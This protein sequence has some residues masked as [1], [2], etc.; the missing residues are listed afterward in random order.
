MRVIC[1]FTELEPE[2]RDAIDLTG[3]QCEYV[4]V[5]GSDDAY[6]ALLAELWKAGREFCIIEHD[7]VPGRGSLDELEDC[8]GD[9]CSF[10]VAYGTGA[11]AGLGCVKFSTRLLGQ[12]PYALERIEARC[13]DTHPPKHW[14]RLDAW[15]NEYLR[16]HEQRPCIH[17]PA[18]THL[19]DEEGP[20]QPSH[21][22]G[23]FG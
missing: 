10:A 8:P 11:H 13:D 17:I 14:C 16:N 18:L 21:G 5:S 19:R 6:W 20:V 2:T 4:D 23:R 22:C 12:L 3:R 7:V 15:L 9:W 1:P